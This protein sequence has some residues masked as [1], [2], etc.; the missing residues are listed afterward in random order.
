MLVIPMGMGMLASG[1][2]MRWS[3]VSGNC[4]KHN[5][6]FSKICVCFFGKWTVPEGTVHFV[7]VVMGLVEAA[8]L[9]ID[10]GIEGGTEREPAPTPS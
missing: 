5:P 2:R 10:A 1:L 3:L 7:V 6:G 4:G 8:V 9:Q